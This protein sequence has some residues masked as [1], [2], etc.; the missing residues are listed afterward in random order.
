MRTLTA[1]QAAKCE[2]ASGR[3]CRCRCGGALHGARRTP[4]SDPGADVDL[5]LDTIDYLRTL[6]EEDPHHI[7]ERPRKLALR[8]AA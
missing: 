2:E 4:F 5:D 6:P 8:G 7:T 1:R 3:R